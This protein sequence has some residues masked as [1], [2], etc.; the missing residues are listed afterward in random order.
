LTNYPPLYSQAATGDTAIT[1][2]AQDRRQLIQALSPVEGIVLQ[3]D[4]MVSQRAAGANM[5]VDVAA[6]S[7]IVHGDTVAGQGSYIARSDAVNNVALAA[8]SSANPRIDLIVLQIN[9]K[10]V[11]GG[12]TYGQAP[13]AITGAPAASPVAPSMPASALLLAQVFVPK[14][15]V[16]ILNTGT[17]V[18]GGTGSITDQRVLS[19]VGDVPKWELYGTPGQTISGSTYTAYNAATVLQAIGVGR[20]GSTITIQTPGRYATSFCVRL[21]FS[22]SACDRQSVIEI[23][24]NGSITRRIA[25]NNLTAANSP[26]GV[27][28]TVYLYAGDSIRPVIWQDAGQTLAVDDGNLEAAFT[29]VWVGP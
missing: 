6:G 14:N 5:S 18:A 26:T 25:N 21:A 1:Y 4:Y 24:H 2:T 27:A 10:Q 19:G 23:T 8:P 15:A 28:G 12:A 7:A 20:S 29:G 9:D 13:I 16:S 22:S 17:N 3:G 11:D